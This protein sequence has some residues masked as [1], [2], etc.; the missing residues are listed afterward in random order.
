[1]RPLKFCS[2]SRISPVQPFHLVVVD[3]ASE[4][5]VWD[6]DGVALWVV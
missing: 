3:L 2:L 6:V 5:D 1:M 4:P